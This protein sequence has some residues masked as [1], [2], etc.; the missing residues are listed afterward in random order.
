MFIY[1]V[2]NTQKRNHPIGWFL[3]C[4]PYVGVNPSGSTTSILPS[5]DGRDALHRGF[6]QSQKKMRRGTPPALPA[7]YSRA[8]LFIDT[9]AQMARLETIHSD[10]FFFVIRMSERTHRVRPQAF[11]ARERCGCIC[12]RGFDVRVKTNAPWHA[13]GLAGRCLKIECRCVIML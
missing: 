11:E 1:S 8:A 13:A 12:S 2:V 9:R 3:F 4:Y 10:G 5:S 7:E 6:W